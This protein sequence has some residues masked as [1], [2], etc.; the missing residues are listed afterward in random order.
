MEPYDIGLCSG[1]ATA[2]CAVSLYT[3][4]SFANPKIPGLKVHSLFQHV[5]GKGNRWLRGARLLRGVAATLASAVLSGE[6]ICHFHFF[7]GAFFELQFV[8]FAKF[9][10][11]KVVITI[12]DV[13]SFTSVEGGVQ[14]HGL[15]ARVYDMADRIVVHNNISRDEVA[16]KLG[17]SPEKIALIRHGNY[18]KEDALRPTQADARKSLGLNT[19]QKVI[20]FFGQI[21]DVKGLDLL[22]RAV[23]LVAREVPE[24][25][26]VIAGRPWKNDFGAYEELIDEVGIRERCIL[27]IRFIPDA[28]IS[29]YFSAA[30]VVTL[31]YRRIYQS[32]VILMSMSLGTPVLVSNLPGMT[33]IISD[34]DNGFVFESNST[35]ALAKALIHALRDEL[36][37][38]RA[39]A[40]AL[41]YVKEFH[42]WTTIG[43]Q[44]AEV[45]QNILSGK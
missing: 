35:E 10:C 21:K 45:Y 42:D 1:L 37:R 15:V 20:L 23:A 25:V 39:A 26:L 18:V 7:H 29:E 16:G 40:K 28:D 13:E 6:K 14:S 31:P 2:G 11:R 17:I 8:I 44:T 33:E 9:C 27:H 38:K 34:G 43:R 32:G 41:E 36:G 24:V 3:S 5:Y 4:D 12:H 30:D 22:I 19:S